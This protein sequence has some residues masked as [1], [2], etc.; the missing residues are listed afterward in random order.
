M[1]RDLA[2]AA[3]QLADHLRF[4]QAL[5]LPGAPLAPETAQALARLAKG[6]RNIPVPSAGGD[7][8][9]SPSTADRSPAPPPAA[10][11]SPSTASADGG[12]YSTDI[13]NLARDAAGCTGCR[14]AGGR[15][16][17]VFGEGH[18]RAEIMFI[19]EGPGADEDRTGRPFVGRA[20][21]LL[22]RIIQAM[23]LSR[24]EVYIANM[25]KCRPPDNRNPK[26][27]EVAA[28]NHWL[29]AQIRTIAPRVIVTLGNVPT[30]SLLGIST[31]ITAAR[32]SFHDW[33]GIPV[34]PTFHPSYL[35]RNYT[36]DA[37]GAVWQDMQ[38]VM[39][40]LGKEPSRP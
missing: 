7:K 39:K 11:E 36:R 34:M 4:Q 2:R 27:D 1:K 29:M 31:G 19:G 26:P 21:Q 20:G 24:E 35:L 13:E 23:G 18:P 12:E 17:V 25:V 32:G 14:L 38:A 5:G 33:Q 15:T 9:G 28:C 10:S 8:A 6:R 30:K 37:R 3:A 22:T 16:T 40:K